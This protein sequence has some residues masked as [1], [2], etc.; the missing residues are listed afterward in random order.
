[1]TFLRRHLLTVLFLSC[2]HVSY[3]FVSKFNFNSRSIRKEN[4]GLNSDKT[5]GD[6]NDNDA[7]SDG[8]QSTRKSFLAQTAI[9]TA[10][11][12]GST[13]IIFSKELPVSAAENNPLQSLKNKSTSADDVLS[14]LKSSNHF[15]QY[16][17]GGTAIVTGGNSGI[18]F[19][20]VAS[21][22]KAGMN[23]ILCTR[24]YEAGLEAKN[25][26]P[27]DLQDKVIVTKLDLSDMNSIEKSTKEIISSPL[28]K[29]GVDVII[30]NA[31]VIDKEGT[32]VLTSQGLELQFGINHVGH[33]MFTRILLPFIKNNGRVVTV[34]S[35]AHRFATNTETV[36]AGKGGYSGS[37]LC[38]ILFAEALQDR[39]MSTGRNDIKSVSL[40]PGVI[41]TPLFDKSGG[42]WKFVPF[43]A[44]R[45]VKQGA[46]TTVLC[47]LA[48]NENING[49]SYYK[50]CSVFPPSVDTSRITRD[51][52][53]DSTE[54]IIANNGFKMPVKLI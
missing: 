6:G 2:S 46:A 33:H 49:G 19:E 36:L 35:E 54:S 25:T 48:D 45:T 12:V 42:L 39:L 44:D 17:N 10:S 15:A 50:D 53:W 20:T 21:L 30:N 52:L 40:H 7:N 18:G 1:M 37:K 16:V 5:H 51:S 41:A 29:N 13:S 26:L 23:V 43:L 34:A 4:K 11:I 38:N 27:A 32:P 47:A 28:A 31:G 8:L 24:R 14:A 9:V 22:A 3:S